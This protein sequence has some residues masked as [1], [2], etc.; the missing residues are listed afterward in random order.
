[1]AILQLPNKKIR[2]ALIEYYNSRLAQHDQCSPDIMT[3]FKA[4]QGQP[5]YGLLYD[6]VENALLFKKIPISDVI[7]FPVDICPFKSNAGQITNRQ[8]TDFD[9]VEIKDDE[10]Q[11]FSLT[12]DKNYLPNFSYQAMK[13]FI[14]FI[15]LVGLTELSLTDVLLTEAPQRLKIE[16]SKAHPIYTGKI[17]VKT[18]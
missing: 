3:D 15:R 10:C 5:T 12:Y 6:R 9:S 14:T 2:Q 8:L 4:C 18:W 16:I 17:E 11:F 13:K 7:D 1:M